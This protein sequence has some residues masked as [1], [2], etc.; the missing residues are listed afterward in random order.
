MIGNELIPLKPRHYANRC[1]NCPRWVDSNRHECCQVCHYLKC[2]C[3]GCWCT[4][5]PEMKAI[6]PKHTLETCWRCQRRRLNP[7]A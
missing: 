7:G 3:G 6:Y 2:E 4:M 1:W 5:P